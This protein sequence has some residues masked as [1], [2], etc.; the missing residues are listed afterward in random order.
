MN[1]VVV[2]KQVPNTS[3]A[4]IGPKTG[5]LIREGVQSII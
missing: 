1:I 4:R 3:V 2:V 5:D